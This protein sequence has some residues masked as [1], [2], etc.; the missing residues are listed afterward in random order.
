VL[1]GGVVGGPDKDDN[2]WDIRSDWVQTEVRINV[3]EMGLFSCH[4]FQQAA[5]GH[6]APLLTLA[7]WKVAT[8]G[9][10]P[11]YAQLK[12][13]AYAARKPKGDRPCQDPYAMCA[14]DFLLTWR[15]QIAVGVVMGLGGAVIVVLLLAY[16]IIY[17]RKTKAEVVGT[18]PVSAHV[19]GPSMDKSIDENASVGHA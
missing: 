9:N 1:Y 6:S 7:A 16:G 17:W 8:D 10:D 5:L 14:S 2:Y 11:Y 3:S 19:S 13:G 18:P 15:E 12:A 4:L